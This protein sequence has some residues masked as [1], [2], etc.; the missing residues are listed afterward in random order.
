MSVKVRVS[1]VVD[2]LPRV[3]LIKNTPLLTNEEKKLILTDMLQDLPLDMFSGPIAKTKDI[4]SSVIHTEIKNVTAQKTP[5]KK[6]TPT[7]SPKK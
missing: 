6:H 4:I 5:K 3:D 7:K 2:L 1:D